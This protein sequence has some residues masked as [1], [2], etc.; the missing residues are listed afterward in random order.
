MEKNSKKEAFSQSMSVLWDLLTEEEQNMLLDYAFIHTYNTEDFIFQAGDTPTHL[1]YLIEGG[2]KML[3]KG[4][5]RQQ[6]IVRMVQPQSFFGYRSAFVD[7]RNSLSAVAICTSKVVMLPLNTLKLLI[8]N[9]HHVS[10]FFIHNIAYML[11]QSMEATITLSQKHMRGRMAE[12]L[13]LAK[14]KYGT[15]SDGKTL[16]IRLSR[17]EWASF[18]NMTT[19]NAIRT[20]SAFASE[21]I[22]KLNGRI[23]SILQ[24]DK[25]QQISD[26][27]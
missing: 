22:L 26:R 15:E 4:I 27:G 9:N 19:S 13:L 7:E 10:D 21:G 24:E 17:A 5:A 8:K 20:I 16:N 6:Q 18:S 12:I 23:I 1:M 25:L 3:K 14:R 2:V 11:A